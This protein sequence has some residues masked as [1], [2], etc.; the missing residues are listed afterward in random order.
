MFAPVGQKWILA[1]IRWW[2]GW[3][4]GEYRDTLIRYLLDELWTYEQHH[5]DTLCPNSQ[6]AN[7]F[8]P[9]E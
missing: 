7:D 9:G 4:L 6:E 2:G 3:A 8:P 1:R 5:S